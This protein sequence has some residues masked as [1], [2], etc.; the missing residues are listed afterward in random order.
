MTKTR[1]A[2]Q[3]DTRRRPSTAR[4]LITMALILITAS[5][6]AAL[7]LSTSRNAEPPAPRV[8]APWEYN[9]ATNQHWHPE[10]G[11]W[12]DGPPPAPGAASTGTGISP[13]I[14]VVP[15]DEQASAAAA[16]PEGL[17]KPWEYNPATNQHWHPEHGHWHDGPPPA[18]A[19]ASGGS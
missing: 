19:G 11:H 6:V 17:P 18:D 12:H 4:W 8:P 7:G 10:H 14:S 16:R 1:H 13:T 2:N 5:A 15:G 3:A 9:A